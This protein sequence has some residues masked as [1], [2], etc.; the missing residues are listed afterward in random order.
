MINRDLSLS[1][2]VEGV[3]ESQRILIPVHF[4]K[5]EI[6]EHFFSSIESIKS[7]FVISDNLFNEG[8]EEECKIIWR[9]QVVL[10]E[11]LLDFYM[12]EISKYCMFQM[13]CGNWEKSDKY[14][15]FM[16]PMSKVE[17]AISATE[18]NEWFFKYLNQRF[19][20]D[21][22]LSV[23]SMREQLNLIGVGFIPVMRKAFPGE[24]DEMS[25]KDG[26]RIITQL[27]K[28]RNEIAHQ[29]DRSHETA[30]QTD[31]TKEFVENY[32]DYIICIVNAVYDVVEDKDNSSI[33]E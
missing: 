17:E 12:H 22:F 6:K 29:N 7:Q 5:E 14:A 21:V 31:I 33:N 25:K 8:R 24:N 11:G 16:V 30:E 32:I 26:S 3:R 20:R 10:A 1:A 28:R 13:F 19:S 18:S 4:T 27:F 15:A 2:R 9:S 23:E